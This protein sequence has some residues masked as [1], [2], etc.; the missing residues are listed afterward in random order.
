VLAV[1][2]ARHGGPEELRLV[3][4]P[5]P[6]AGPGE[7]VVRNRW[8]GVNYVDLQHRAGQPPGQDPMTRHLLASGRYQHLVTDAHAA[9]ITRLA[10]AAVVDHHDQILFIDG[11]AGLDPAR[12]W[13]LPGGTV[14]PGQTLTGMFCV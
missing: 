1:E 6:V 5:D 12:T 13:D 8:I 14:P 3:E 11:P 10:I 2:I 9:G 7:L 4:A